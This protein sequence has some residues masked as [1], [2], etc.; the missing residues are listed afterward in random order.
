MGERMN[1]PGKS[2]LALFALACGASA[3]CAAEPNPATDYDRIVD[4]VVARYHLPG[5]AVGV[6]DDGK[7]VYTRVHGK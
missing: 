4:A 2:I 5:I 7:V 1:R 6:I 3:A